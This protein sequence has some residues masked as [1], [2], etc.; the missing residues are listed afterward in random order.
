[1]AFLVL[2]IIKCVLILETSNAAKI[3]GIFTFPARSHNILATRLLAGLAEDGHEITF[4]APYP[5]KNI[6]KN[7]SWNE[8][9][10]E[11]LKEEHNSYLNQIDIY[12]DSN[13]GL[14]DRLQLYENVMTCW[15]NVT[16]FH[17]KMRALMASNNKFDV[18]IMEDF[19]NSAHKYFA[20]YYDCPLILLSPMG[21][22]SFTADLL[23]NPL[24][25]A[26]VPHT[27]I[28]NTFDFR[29][30]WH[31]LNNVVSLCSL[32]IIE[33][34]YT[35]PLHARL[36]KAAFPDSPPLE[37]LNQRVALV[38]LNSHQSL[39]Q[40][41]PLVPNIVNIG[42]Y[43]VDTPKDLPQDLQNFMDSAKEGVIYFSMGSNLKAKNMSEEKK[44]IFFNVFKRL[45]QK[46]LWKFEDENVMGLP[47]NVFI[48]S[49]MPQ[50]DILAHPNV[51]LFITHGGLLSTTEA[52][53]H[54]VPMLTIPVFADQFTN[55]ATAVQGGYGLRISYN[56]PNFNEETLNKL[57][58]LLLIDPK[59][60]ENAKH[61]S[62]VYN[63]RPMKP[64]ETLVYWVNYVIRHK[65]AEHL[66]VAGV[67]LQNYQYL[68][69]DIY[70]PAIFFMH[71]GFY[72]SFRIV[73]YIYR[74]FSTKKS[75]KK[76][77]K[78]KIQ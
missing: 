62:K 76:S 1:M 18:V 29:N 66:K 53:H 23:R 77:K 8:I 72:L 56:D 21:L 24:P 5:T 47:K 39:I 50:Q 43:H 4:V 34:F 44:Q 35:L 74:R 40:P 61:R 46:I 15:I 28:S 38:L 11:G 60:R 70:I 20:H 37:E 19:F 16:M 26:Y 13:L 64:M 33:Y 63:D 27:M 75:G 54:G 59:Y 49:W 10:L 67:H 22:T 71:V 9:V 58:D 51:K 12:E 2:L 6:P 52:I 14:M 30:Y 32:H 48:M 65:G 41:I 42:G 73:R 45:K 7:T 68:M 78:Q 17:P 55:A 36:L 31:R 57:I 69:L 25:P 3:L